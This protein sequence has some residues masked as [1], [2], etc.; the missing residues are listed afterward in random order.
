MNGRTFT[1]DVTF[2]YTDEELAAAAEGIGTARGRPMRFVPPGESADRGARCYE[3]RIADTGEVETR[4]RNW[5]D[6]FNALAWIAFP[7]A[8]SRI[9]AQHAALLEE[10]GA[11]ETEDE[12][13]DEEAE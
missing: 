7:R 2:Q 10:R 4:E 12:E 3:L 1:A 13:E 9:N 8:K 11:A 5:H 6:L